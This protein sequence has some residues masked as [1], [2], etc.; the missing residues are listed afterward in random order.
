MAEEKLEQP[1]A[2][3]PKKPKSFRR[4]EVATW[5]YSLPWSEPVVIQVPRYVDPAELDDLVAHFE[6]VIRQIR[7]N[8]ERDER[9]GI[10][11]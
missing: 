10:P 5:H 2:T 11:D 6:M 4:R 1:S 3:P 9:E 8:S 7:R